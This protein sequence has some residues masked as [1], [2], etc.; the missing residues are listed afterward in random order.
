MRLFFILLIFTI[1]SDVWSEDSW[2]P[3]DEYSIQMRTVAQLGI[4]K[5]T[6]CT[7][8]AIIGAGIAGL[9]AALELSLSGHQVTIY[10]SS[11][12]VGGRVFTYH[13]PINGYITELGA[14]RLPLDVH[15]L[16]QTYINRLKLTYAKFVNNNPNGIIYFNDIQQRVS[17]TK[18]ADNFHFNVED[19][20]RGMVSFIEKKTKR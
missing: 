8:I 6:Q 10:E 4:A 20:E 3:K 17:E 5:C 15:T 11:N 9:T 2:E 18:G 14:M 12:R 1:F 16:L 13:D 19:S 7:N